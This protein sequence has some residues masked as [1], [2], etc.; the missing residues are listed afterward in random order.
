MEEFAAI[1]GFAKAVRAAKE[2]FN[3]AVSMEM[4]R[5][6]DKALVDYDTFYFIMMSSYV[7][8]C[9]ETQECFVGNHF[10]YLAKLQMTDDTSMTV[11]IKRETFRDKFLAEGKIVVDT[12]EC[13]KKLQGLWNDKSFIAR[14]EIS[15]PE[16]LDWGKRKYAKRTLHFSGM[17]SDSREIVTYEGIEEVGPELSRLIP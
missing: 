11:F 3:E 7:V 14:M 15:E 4:V 8:E 16:C 10:G 13:M 12:A 1:E 17:S 6:W 5:T 9:V 2:A